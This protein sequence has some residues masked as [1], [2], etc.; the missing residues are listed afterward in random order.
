MFLDDEPSEPEQVKDFY[1]ANS[2]PTHDHGFPPGG[3]PKPAH[4]ER[5]M[6]IGG[7]CHLNKLTTDEFAVFELYV[8]HCKYYRHRQVQRRYNVDINIYSL[9]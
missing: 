2:S 4:P 6:P 3:I 8:E 1:I 7:G 5:N 9:N